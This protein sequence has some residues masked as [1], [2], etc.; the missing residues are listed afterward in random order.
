MLESQYMPLC[1]AILYG[2]EGWQAPGARH[3]EDLGFWAGFLS[4][5]HMLEDEGEG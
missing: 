1:L 5:A 2:S 3:R 4:T